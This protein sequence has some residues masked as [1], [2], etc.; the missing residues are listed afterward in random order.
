M[1]GLTSHQQQIYNLLSMQHTP[2]S[3]DLLVR[4]SNELAPHLKKLT[5]KLGL[6]TREIQE[7]VAIGESDD[8]EIVYQ[9]L[10]YWQQKSQQS[11]TVAVLARVLRDIH[12]S[13]M[14]YILQ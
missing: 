10:R 9:V 4:L 13:H 12:C 14:L 11:A 2:V 6:N 5:D 1:E 8:R 3:E 7:C